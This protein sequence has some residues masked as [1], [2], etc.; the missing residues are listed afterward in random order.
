VNG[1]LD[2]TIYRQDREITVYGIVERLAKGHIGE[3]PYLFP[4]VQ[5]ETYYLWEIVEARPYYYPL[6]G[7]YGG[8]YPFYGFYPPY[9]FYPFWWWY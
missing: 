3:H 4:V 8:F 2:P 6:Y 5:V 7:P 9:G 1:F